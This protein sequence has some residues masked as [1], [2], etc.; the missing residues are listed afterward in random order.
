MI[1]LEYA[2]AWLRQPDPEDDELIEGLILDATYYVGQSIGWHLG[3]PSASTLYIEGRGENTIYL[4]QPGIV[5]DVLGEDG[6]SIDPEEWEVR[7]SKL[8]RLE[9]VWAVGEVYQIEWI[10]GF[11]VG[12][13]PPDLRRAV[14][15]LVASW[16]EDR[17][18]Y[19]SATAVEE[20]PQSVEKILGRYRRLLA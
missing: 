20:I 3:E 7:G 14:A 13:G 19:V 17:E 5:A 15:M 16:Y 18:G 1:S 6:D 8:V 11:D 9:G 10:R 2:R 4:G 12:D